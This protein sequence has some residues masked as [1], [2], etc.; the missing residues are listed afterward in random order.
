MFDAAFSG[1]GGFPCANLFSVSALDVILWR[2]MQLSKWRLYLES[3]VLCVEHK[4][5]EMETFSVSFREKAL[6]LDGFLR[7]IDSRNHAINP[8][9]LGKKPVLCNVTIP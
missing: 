1:V 9:R 5:K 3:S 4:E 6:L 2:K 7:D 8:S